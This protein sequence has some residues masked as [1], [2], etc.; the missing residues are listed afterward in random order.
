MREV[1]LSGIDL[2]LLPA[3]EALL[4]RRN[5]THAAAEVG[6]SQPAMSRGLARLRETFGDPLLVRSGGKL[7][8]TPFARALAPKVA[9]ALD[10]LR[11]LF[12]APDFDPATLQRV[13]RLAAADAQTILLAPALMARLE[14]QAPG[15]DL[16]FQ[17]I[18]RDIM[19]RMEQGDADLCF[20]T[21]TTPL[22]PGV[23]SD[24]IAEDRLA[25]VMRRGHPAAGRDF[26]LA[27]YAR[28]SHATVSFFADGV[29]E[30]DARL[31][32]AGIARRIALTTPHFMGTVAAVAGS[33]LV[34]TISAAFAR[35]F[36]G[37]LGLVLRPPPF[38]DRLE[39]TVVGL[40][41]RAA[42]PAIR[43]FRGVLKEEA[44]AVYSEGRGG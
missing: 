8:A 36:A 1:N 32:S 14:R 43:W 33:D 34:T 31:A 9:A 25:L 13:V 10:E 22:P 18:G 37:P 20:A 30:I 7:A 27:D 35:R 12:A 4:R 21:G 28:Y 17:P 3:L 15:V 24:T 38:D 19:T 5:V 26:G 2:N 11:G 29:S 41:L 6:L 40:K 44:A 23:V 39:L 16:S 42:D